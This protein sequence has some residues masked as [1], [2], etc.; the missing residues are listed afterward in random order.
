MRLELQGEKAGRH[1]C[2]TGFDKRLQCSMLQKVHI[3][4]GNRRPVEMFRYPNLQP[5]HRRVSSGAGIRSPIYHRLAL[6]SRVLCTF[7]H[8]PTRLSV[9]APLN[10]VGVQ[11]FTSATSSGPLLASCN[12]GDTHLCQRLERGRAGQ[13]RGRTT[14]TGKVVC[15]VAV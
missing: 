4:S 11:L 12:G 7:V 6:V 10:A 13:R 9:L 15:V 8:R 14:R 5:D 1:W 3:F 2:G